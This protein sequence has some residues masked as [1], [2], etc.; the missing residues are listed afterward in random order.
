VALRVLRG[1][2][3]LGGF[4]L[5]FIFRRAS[6]QSCCGSRPVTCL[7]QRGGR[8]TPGFADSS[9]NHRLESARLADRAQ[10]DVDENSAEHDQ[11]GDIVQDVA[12]RDRILPKVLAP[13]TGQRR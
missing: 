10:V 3:C 12:D 5:L 11:R 13:A 4:V 9:A 7:Y 8:S 2:D 6:S 1:S